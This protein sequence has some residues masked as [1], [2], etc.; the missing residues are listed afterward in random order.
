[1]MNAW[2]VSE[3]GHPHPL[4]AAPLIPL[5]WEREGGAQR[6]KGEAVKTYDT[7]RTGAS[8]RARQLRRTSTEVEK[9]LVRALREK[10]PGAK[11]RH[12]MP[13]GP[14]FVDVACFASRLVIELD[15][16]QHAE[17][18]E[19]DCARTRFIEAQGYRVLRFW[20]NDVIENMDGVLEKIAAALLPLTLGEGRGE[21]GQLSGKNAP[22]P[23]RASP[24]LPLPVG[25]G[26]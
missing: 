17:A 18:V 14:Y 25:E 6:R 20:N 11:W 16:S 22:S 15:G 13:V 3:R 5:P 1:M 26:V 7:A 9:R 24:S 12:Q 2:R 19:Y 8:L 21:G 4:A 23:F 10:L